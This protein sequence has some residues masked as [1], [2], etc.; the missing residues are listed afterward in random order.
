MGERSGALLL[1]CSARLTILPQHIHHALRSM[2]E[3]FIYERIKE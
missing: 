3:S 2:A 1:V